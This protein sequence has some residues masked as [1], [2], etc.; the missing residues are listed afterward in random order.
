MWIDC[1]TKDGWSRLAYATRGEGD[2]LIIYNFEEFHGSI[3]MPALST[4]VVLREL[5]NNVASWQKMMG[6]APFD[7]DTYVRLANKVL[8][9]DVDLFIYYDRWFRDSDYRVEIYKKLGR[10]TPVVNFTG[11]TML[12]VDERQRIGSSFD[13]HA[14]H[15]RA[16]E[17]N[18]LRRYEQVE[19]Q[20]IPAQMLVLNELIKEKAN[21]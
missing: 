1:D 21:E 8:Q 7:Y 14:Y 11:G 2:P 12:H 19:L 18:V 6:D 9:D 4:I 15:G 20:P 5:Q 16:Q 13:G 17:M 3:P 10:L